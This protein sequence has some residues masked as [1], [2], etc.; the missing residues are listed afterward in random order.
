MANVEYVKSGFTGSED[1]FKLT[2]NGT[3]ETAL[4]APENESNI[5]T[6]AAYDSAGDIVT[7]TVGTVTVS[8]SPIKGQ[9]LVDPSIGAGV[10]NL[11]DAGPSAVYEMPLYRGQV[12]GVI[13]VIADVDFAA[14]V[15]HIKVQVW[16]N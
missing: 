6:L 4:L 12:I 2:E 15:D 11:S 7:A 10:I 5:V 8:C 13:A 3:F 1:D 14:E 16:S 9:W